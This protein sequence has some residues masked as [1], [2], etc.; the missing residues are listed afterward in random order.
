[1]NRFI[2]IVALVSLLMLSACDG[3][4]VYTSSSETASSITASVESYLQEDPVPQKDTAEIDEALKRYIERSEAP[5]GILEDTPTLFS[6]RTITVVENDNLWNLAHTTYGR[7]DQYTVIHEANRSIIGDNPSLISIGQTLKIPYLIA[8]NSYFFERQF[9]PS[10]QS[11]IVLPTG[12][13]DTTYNIDNRA[14]IF[15]NGYNHIIFSDEKSQ[16]EFMFFLID[17]ALTADNIFAYAL[18]QKDILQNEISSISFP[19]QA[20]AISREGTRTAYF[21]YVMQED[22]SGFYNIAFMTPIGDKVL[23][24]IFRCLL[25][26]SEEW[27][28]FMYEIMRSIL[29][30][31]YVVN[32]KNDYMER[33]VRELTGIHTDDIIRSDLD[34][35]THILFETRHFTMGG[36]RPVGSTSYRFDT[37]DDSIYFDTDEPIRDLDDLAHFRSITRLSVDLPDVVNAE[38]LAGLQRL[39]Q[40]TLSLSEDITDLRSIGRV[41][42]LEKLT[43]MVT[44]YHNVEDISFFSDL[45]NL[46]FLV[47]SNHSIKDVQVFCCMKNLTTLYIWAHDEV[48]VQPLID[49]KQ[50]QNLLVNAVLIREYGVNTGETL[51]MSNFA[52]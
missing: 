51:T 42:E 40:A 46:E 34:Q 21:D 26:D 38:G 5:K 31:S 32:W 27:Q 7:G 20:D 10:V 14:M 23:A 6:E 11:S 24:G 35:F 19:S 18:M 50:I 22:E 25:V 37:A 47:F 48:D 44:D 4:S 41:T 8:G 17:E 15:D 16:T 30:D 2:Y 52:D 3:K 12:F 43:L 36:I 28:P 13:Y 49:N 33:I 1:M 39:K 29:Y 9:L 45:H